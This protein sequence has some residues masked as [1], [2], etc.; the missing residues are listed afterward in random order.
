MSKTI[1]LDLPDELYAILND[2]AAKSQK[3]FDETLLEAMSVL[4]DPLLS[5]SDETIEQE[6]AAL[7]QFS[8]AQLWAVMYRTFPPG[9]L[10]RYHELTEKN[11]EDRLTTAE[12]KDLD[13]LIERA[14]LYML[15]RSEALLLLK[16]RGY[17]IHA[18]KHS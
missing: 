12:E 8:D 1:T 6:L 16:T 17:D 5:L 4:I 14:D 7:S 18:W 3:S 2:I 13:N 10:A 15:L 11:K 9:Q